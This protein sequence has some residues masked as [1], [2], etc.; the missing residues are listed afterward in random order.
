L[1]FAFRSL[2]NRLVLIGTVGIST[3]SSPLALAV[4]S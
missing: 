4:G 3:F 1:L 2:V